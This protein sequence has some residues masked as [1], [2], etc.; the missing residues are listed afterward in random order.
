MS[1]SLLTAALVALSASVLVADGAAKD[2]PA[3]AATRKKLKTKVKIDVKNEFFREVLAEINE[4]VEEAGHTPIGWK[5][6]L[7]V[8]MNTRVTFK[9]EGT[10]EEVL[11]KLLKIR[12][13]GYIVIS[14]PGDRYDGWILIKMGKERGYPEKKK[15]E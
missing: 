11:D 10:V 1:R 8:S 2:T 14:K 6:D 12:E 9:G 13:L 15:D 5:Y 3:A 4:Y 7:G